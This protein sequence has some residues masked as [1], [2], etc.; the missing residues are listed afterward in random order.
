[1]AVIGSNT[2]V[3]IGISHGILAVSWNFSTQKEAEYV[4]GIPGRFHRVIVGITQ[5]GT[6]SVG[7]IGRS[8]IGPMGRIVVG[9]AVISVGRQGSQGGGDAVEMIGPGVPPKGVPGGQA[10]PVF[11]WL[12]AV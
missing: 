8:G 1:M 9:L 11:P 7:Q 6:L 12:L 10:H 4:L 2:A 3:T 5:N